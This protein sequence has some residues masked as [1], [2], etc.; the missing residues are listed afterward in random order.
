MKKT[1]VITALLV[2]VIGFTFAAYAET[3]AVPEWVEQMH[4]WRQERLEEALDEGLV[5][6]EQAEWRQQRWE[7]M[8]AWHSERNYDNGGF[9]FCHNDDLR[10]GGFHRGMGGFGGGSR[11][12]NADR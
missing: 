7:A 11:F 12:N 10:G 1:L 9:G 3:R 2:L 5:T 4:Q 6:P 8:D